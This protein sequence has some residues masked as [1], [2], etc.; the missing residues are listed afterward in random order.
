[1]ELHCAP[2]QLSSSQ[3]SCAPLANPLIFPA[4]RMSFSPPFIFH[5]PF[6]PCALLAA[7][8][9]KPFHRAPHPIDSPEVQTEALAL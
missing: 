6:L 7:Q 3:T 9:D 2:L 1:M 5:L 8:S 4:F